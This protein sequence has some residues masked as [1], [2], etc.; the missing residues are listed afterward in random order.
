MKKIFAF[1][2]VGLA[3]S[4][5]VASSVSCTPGEVNT[6][7]TVVKD[8]VDTAQFVCIMASPLTD[9]QALAIACNLV[10]EGEKVEPTVLAFIDQLIAQR[11]TLKKA[12]YSYDK[13]TA[14]WSKP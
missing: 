6:V 9:A 13:P 14:K 3:L 12:G 5:V 8:V 11:E 1:A 10:K 2:F 7:N 4:G